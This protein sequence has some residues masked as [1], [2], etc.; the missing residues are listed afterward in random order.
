[1]PMGPK[2][3][4][5][6]LWNTQIIDTCIVFPSWH[7]TSNTSFILSFIVILLLGVLY[8]Y[9]RFVQRRI[10]VYI[11]Q[12]I[13][14]GERGKGRVRSPIRSGSV[15]P[16]GGEDRALLTGRKL[17]TVSSGPG[18]P[19]PFAY[20]LIRAGVYGSTVFLSFFLMLVFMTYNAY[21][22]LAVVLGA[23]VGHFKFGKKMNVEAVLAD[24][25]SLKGMAC[26]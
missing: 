22:I 10:D 18:L 7:I 19:V 5:H 12:A 11:A 9:L 15:S 21:L 4:M 24:N 16:A 20:R 3:A 17:F 13:S 25:A 23:A 2:C 1:M 6:M 26:H 14:N 8:E